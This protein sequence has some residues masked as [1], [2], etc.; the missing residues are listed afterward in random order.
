MYYLGGDII[1]QNT[2]VMFQMLQ[3]KRVL[4]EDYVS[5]DVEA[6][7]TLNKKLHTDTRINITMLGMADGVTLAFKK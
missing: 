1:V 6:I 5:E 4:K 2:S 3:G 7:K